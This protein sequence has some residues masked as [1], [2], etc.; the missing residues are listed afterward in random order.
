MSHIAY[1]YYN[2]TVLP[3][4]LF[5]TVVKLAVITQTFHRVIYTHNYSIS[6]IN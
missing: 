2:N 1:T 3:K 4:S 5:V 6:I